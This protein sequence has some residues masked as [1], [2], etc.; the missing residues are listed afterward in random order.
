[1]PCSTNSVAGSPSSSSSP[2]PLPPSPAPSLVGLGRLAYRRD[3]DVAPGSIPRIAS[4][5][6]WRAKGG[7]ESRGSELMA[8]NRSGQA[9]LQKQV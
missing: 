2:S 3:G 1:M 7:G 9:E 8:D 4:L 6:V 5:I